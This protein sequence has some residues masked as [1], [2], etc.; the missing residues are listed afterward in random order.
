MVITSQIIKEKWPKCN[1]IVVEEPLT[2][3]NRRNLMAKIDIF[4][5]YE[6]FEIQLYDVLNGLGFLIICENENSVK[7]FSDSLHYVIRLFDTWG[8]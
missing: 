7:D 6:E 2:K 4:N 5:S 3:I 1:I 8:Y